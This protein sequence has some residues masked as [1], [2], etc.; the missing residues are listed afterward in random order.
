M[1]PSSRPGA[2][3]RERPTRAG[4]PLRCASVGAI[5][6]GDLWRIPDDVR[7]VVVAVPGFNVADRVAS[8]GE[9]V[10]LLLGQQVGDDGAVVEVCHVRG[11]LCCISPIAD[12]QREGRASCQLNPRAMRTGATRS[13][14]QGARDRAWR[15]WRGPEWSGRAATPQAGLNCA[16]LPGLTL[17]DQQACVCPGVSGGALVF[18]CFLTAVWERSLSGAA[19]GGGGWVGMSRLRSLLARFTGPAEPMAAEDGAAQLRDMRA[20]AVGALGEALVRA[21]LEVL[22]WPMLRNVI[23]GAPGRSVEIDQ[24]VRAPGG[25]IVLETKTYSGHVDGDLGS[26]CW[27]LSLRDGRSFVVPNAVVQK[28][29]CESVACTPASQSPSQL[30]RLCAGRLARLVLAGSG[31]TA[32]EQ[33]T[34]KR[35]IGAVVAQID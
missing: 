11:S 12:E 25:V 31:Q 35:A 16:T 2:Y 10:V 15:A 26:E 32:L 21:E 1:T 14:A 19:V 33:S 34:A 4:R 17:R 30:R 28:T 5:G 29:P 18:V 8:G 22:G 9:A 23:L 13:H 24:L 20:V 3:M 6:F 27:I 7:A